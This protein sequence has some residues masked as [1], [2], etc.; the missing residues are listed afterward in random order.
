MGDLNLDR[1]R[2]DQRE[3]K[4]LLDLEEIHGLKCLISEP[5]RVTQNHSSLLDVILTNK[6]ELFRQSGVYN[7]EVS[8]HCMIYGVVKERAVQHNK[9]IVQVRS[10]KN[11]DE[12]RF[13]EDLSMAPWLV[14]EVFDSLDD[15]YAYWDTLLK[16]IVNEHLPF[17]DIKVRDNDVP[18]MTK[19][20]KN[21]IKAKRRFSKKYSKSPTQ[22]NFKLKRKW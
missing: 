13:E 21:A 7:P 14:G 16:S 17:R 9:K 18:Y 6:P 19:E 10:Y 8:D 20:W 4:I 1:L 15:R 22:E 3:G 2:P 5:T 12:E 11:L